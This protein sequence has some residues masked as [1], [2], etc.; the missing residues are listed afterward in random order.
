MQ[1]M[2]EHFSACAWA[3]GASDSVAGLIVPK[4]LDFGLNGRDIG[5]PGFFEHLPL[6][7]RQ[8]FALAAEPDTLVISQFMRQGDDFDVFGLDDF[9]IA[10]GL[11]Q[12][13]P[14]QCRY[15]GF[16]SGFQV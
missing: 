10:I 14:N 6:Q 2:Q 16:S 13:R 9:G 4:L 1:K 11:F 8:S 12:Q 5:V 3:F 15:L 7:R